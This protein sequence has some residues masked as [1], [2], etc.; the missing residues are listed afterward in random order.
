MFE[1]AK[2]FYEDNYAVEISVDKLGDR[3][4]KSVI[5]KGKKNV[6]LE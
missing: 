2:M 6:L 4:V 1:E 5:Q 3:T